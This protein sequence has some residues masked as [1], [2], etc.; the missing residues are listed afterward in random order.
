MKKLI[1]ALVALTLITTTMPA[2]ADLK[3]KTSSVP[4]LAIMDTALDTSI[5]S[6]KEKLIGE[7]CIIDKWATC[8]NKTGFMEGPGAATLPSAQLATRDM[9]HGTQ[10]TSIAIANNPNM[11]ILFVRIIGNTNAGTT[12]STTINTVPN[13]LKWIYEN[14]DKYNIK[15]VS[16]SQ[17][18]HNLLKGTNYCP[19]TNTD[20]WVDWLSKSNIPVFF[21]SGNGRDYQRID[22][23]ACIPGSV[24]VGGVEQDVDYAGKTNLWVSSNSNYD[25]KLLD[26][27]A[28]MNSSAIFPGGFKG[29]AYG[30][31]VST[32]I[33]AAKWIELSQSKS[34]LTI[35]QLVDL[36]K[37]TGTPVTNSNNSSGIMFDLIKAING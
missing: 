4:T 28:P 3:S 34:T 9:N 6:I 36:I 5:P 27:F 17:G 24:S 8:P 12:Q 16:M 11:N 14:K 15:A 31:S 18:H 7:V 13:A 23:P 21:P 19:V 20:Y 2:Q 37:K 22:W 30:T 29:N 25:N 33:A 26:I 1:M 10:M 32:Q 35:S